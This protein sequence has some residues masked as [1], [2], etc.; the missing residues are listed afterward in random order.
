MI[1]RAPDNLSLITELLTLGWCVDDVKFPL[2]G[3]K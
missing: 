3:I 2:G 1:R